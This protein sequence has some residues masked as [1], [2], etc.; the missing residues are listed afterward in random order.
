[1]EEECGSS[2]SQ[3]NEEECVDLGLPVAVDGNKRLGLVEEVKS[4]KSLSSVRTLADNNKK[5]YSC[6][7]DDDSPRKKLVV[8]QCKRKKLI[9]IAHDK[10][11][12]VG[13]RQN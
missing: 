6:L 7:D 1:M 3:L 8:P 11:G 13:S 10:S 12:H 5:S 2:P 9:E 4:D